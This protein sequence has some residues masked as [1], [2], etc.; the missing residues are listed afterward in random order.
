MRILL[1]PLLLAVV[2]CALAPTAAS[3]QPSLRQELSRKFQAE[4]TRIAD[5]A[6][7]VV[8]ISV[9]DVT[10]GQ[11]FGVNDTLVFAQ[12]S[13]I[14]IP[15][16]IELYRRADARELKLSDRAP[17]R[18][19][20]QTGGSGLLQFFA[21]GD[22][23]LS[24]RDLAIPMIVLSDNTA[25]NM[26]IDRLGM[27]RVSK[28]MADLGAPQ[29]RLQRKMIRP[30]ESVKGNENVSTPR[31]A[32]DLMVRLAK[33]DLPMSAASCAEVA[34]ILEIPKP[35]SFRGPIP[36]S[37]R[38]AWK[39]GGLEGVQTAWGLVRVPARPYAI[40]VMVNYGPADMDATIE[41]VSAAAY[42]YFS[43][44]ARTTAYGTRVPLEYVTKPDR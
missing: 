27:E 12:G 40:A 13:A 14:K 10:D 22:S 3:A 38:A 4:L 35:G 9:V 8:G 16:L 25:T 44:I 18:A 26:L 28:T 1:R 41:N 37:I 39:P 43:Q 11:R 30:E 2:A 31:E 15:I 32:A 19:E 34:R 17:I 29:T 23:E 6:A 7:G 36:G 33:C 21:A 24:L 20:D 5:E 42:R